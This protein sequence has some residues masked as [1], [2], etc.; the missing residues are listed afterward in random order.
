MKKPTTILLIRHGN[1]G[2]DPKTQLPADSLCKEGRA[3]VEKL[4]EFLNGYPISAYFSSPYRR[5]LETAEIIAGSEK[6]NVD[7]R[8]REIPLWSDPKDLEEDEKRLELTKILIE[9]QEGVEGV[10]ENVQETYPGETVAFVCHG[11]IIRATLAFTLKM[12]LETAVRLQ[13]Y[14]AAVS[15]IERT[16]ED[17]YALR[18]FNS[19]PF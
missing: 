18:L 13:T 14:T 6:I 5:A 3:E 19:K 17:Y 15:I 7:S 11:N 1:T 9:A 10:L 12:G 8:L 16:P 4:A 2:K